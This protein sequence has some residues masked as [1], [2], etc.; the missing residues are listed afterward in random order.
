M[1]AT[2]READRAI[3]EL[4]FRGVEVWAHRDRE[5]LDSEYYLPL[6]EKMSQYNLPIWMHPMRKPDPDYRSEKES[7]Y[8][9]WAIFGWP[10]DTTTA[11][12][13]MVFS[14]VFERFPN[15]KIITHHCG[16][17]VPFFA[18]RIDC[19]GNLM[20]DCTENLSRPMLDYFRMFYADTALEGGKPA[21]K[22]GYDFFGPEHMLFGTDMPMDSRIG[23]NSIGMAIEAIE[24]ID[25]PTEEKKMIFEG[26][27]RRLLRLPI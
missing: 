2:L 24:E 13:R 21:L 16:A 11:M 7:K 26:N 15:L 10:Y 5:P 17:M 3:R 6:Y 22:C 27:A 4:K 20:P 12:A 19:L 25:I 23:I 1:D 9:I 18:S 14:G 8:H